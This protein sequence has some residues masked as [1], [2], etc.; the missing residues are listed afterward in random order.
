[1]YTFFG[2][3]VDFCRH[4][5]ISSLYVLSFR[6]DATASTQNRRQSVSFLVLIHCSAT[7][8]GLT[9]EAAAADYRDSRQHAP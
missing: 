9:G 4:T 1:M 7:T 6:L 3:L 5:A 8:R 2:G